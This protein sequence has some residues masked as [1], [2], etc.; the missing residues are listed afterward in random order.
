MQQWPLN[1]TLQQGENFHSTQPPTLPPVP[2]P[3]G[4]ILLLFRPQVFKVLV[5]NATKP[6]VES[7]AITNSTK[8]E[9]QNYSQGFRQAW[10]HPEETKVPSPP[11][12]GPWGAIDEI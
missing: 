9:P 10:I 1:L 12:P 6:F 2:Q 11:T 8:N 7:A 4:W 5:T 3:A